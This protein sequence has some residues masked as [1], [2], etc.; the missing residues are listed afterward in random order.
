MN[1][2]TIGIVG[3]SGLYQMDELTDVQET[4][5]STPFG[6][7]SDTIMVGKL[8]NARVA[9][10]ARH[11]RHHSLMPSEVPYR[12]NVYALKQLGVRYL[13]SVSAVGSLKEEMRPRDIVLPSQFIDR[14]QRRESSFF[15]GG[16][17]AHVAFANPVC[18]ALSAILTDA[19]RL[20]TPDVSFHVGGTYVCIEGPA[21]STLAE[22]ALHRS[23][24]AAVVGMTNLPEARL[25]REAEM[26]Y[27]TLA[28]VTDY[29]C[30]HPSHESVTVEM[31]IANL[32]HNA[33]NAKKILAHA[34]TQIAE[35][36]PES[37]A[38]EALRTALVTPP[39]QIGAT[40]RERLA[41]IIGK[42]LDH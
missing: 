20:A 23:W 31:A 37:P 5:I 15:G 2:V 24:D 34:I 41:A 4:G 14:T 39:A 40:S 13:L 11:G 42:Y 27:A 26:A 3:G 16:V 17:V 29:D 33:S 38:H 1:E 36:P 10:L 9:F 6:A 30:W 32:Q 28:L 18:P 35:A 21:F 25:A 12:A 22:A 8:G 7:P 19:I